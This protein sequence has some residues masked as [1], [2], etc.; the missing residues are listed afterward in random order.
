MGLTTY[1]QKREF[2][3]TPEPFGRQRARRGHSFVVQEHAARRLH[4]D[5][6]LEINGVLKSWSVP[7]GPSLDPRE[8]RLA[9][10]TED[11]PLEYARFEG[12]IPSG[13]GAGT[14]SV[15]DRGAYRNLRSENDKEVPMSRAFKEGKLEF[16]LEGTK[17]RGGFA[18]VRTGRDGNWLLIK[19]R[20]EEAI[21]GWKPD[22]KSVLSG[23]TLEDIAKGRSRARM[24]RSTPRTRAS[25][26]NGRETSKKQTREASKKQ[27]KGL[28]LNIGSHEI[29]LSK[30][31][32]ELY[33][34]QYTKEGVV[35]YYRDIAP[36]MLPYLR[37]RPLSMQRYP[38]GIAGPTFFQKEIPDYF[39]EWIPRAT[40]PRREGGG[41]T[42]V[43]ANDAATLAYLAAQACLVLHV[44]LCRVDKPDIPDRL[45]FDLDPPDADMFP[46]VKHAAFLLRGL[47]EEE[48][49]LTAAPMLT[50]SR[51]VHVI[52]PLIR[53]RSFDDVRAFAREVANVFAS[54][55]P[56]LVTVEHLK[57]KRAG[58]IYV[59]VARNAFGQTAVPPYSLR[60]LPHAPIATPVTWDELRRSRG[61]RSYTL[62][63]IRRRLSRTGDPWTDLPPAQGLDK[64]R[65]TAHRLIK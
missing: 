49:Q 31:D 15:W 54:R 27:T 1:H 8:K 38:D 26:S 53:R 9:V 10:P 30:P 44:G 25:R 62:A 13:Y 21:S 37:E 42:H 28:G 29:V 20:D 40:L 65:R 48:L 22:P 33:P 41:I 43:L 2:T 51:G 56:D 63:N 24:S 58:R 5:F 55:A 46:Q 32:K 61:A 7:K 3:S 19:K 57:S 14:V 35:A 11:H 23:R 50:G 52:I 45:I 12:I 60:A 64:A 4:Y 18:L 59:D 36:V 47:L 16:F 6:R 34:G 39:P 17:L